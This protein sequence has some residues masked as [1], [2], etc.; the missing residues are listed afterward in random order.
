MAGELNVS[1]D[2]VS[3]DLQQYVLA[4]QQQGLQLGQ[5]GTLNTGAIDPVT[6]QVLFP[7]LPQPS[8]LPAFG[9]QAPSAAFGMNDPLALERSAASVMMG[10]TFEAEMRERQAMETRR[11]LLSAGVEAGL[12]AIPG[13]G[14][15]L[16]IGYGLLSDKLYDAIGLW[17]YD[18]DP[19]FNIEDVTKASMADQ[20]F[21][22]LYQNVSGYG[23]G[24]RGIGFDATLEAIDLAYG[25]I[26]DLGFQGI[27]LGRIAPMLAQSGFLERAVGG[28]GGLDD[29]QAL[30][31]AM[32]NAMTTIRDTMRDVSLSLLESAQ[33]MIRASSMIRSTD[34]AAMSDASRQLGTSAALL[35]QLT[36]RTIEEA[37]TGYIDPLFQAMTPYMPQGVEP[38]GALAAAAGFAEMANGMGRVGMSYGAVGGA[39]WALA[40]QAQAIQYWLTPFGSRQMARMLDMNEGGFRAGTWDSSVAGLQFG[41]DALASFDSAGDRWEAEYWARRTMA[42]TPQLQ[43]EALAAMHGPTIARID[44]ETDSYAGLIGG[45]AATYGEIAGHEVSDA[46]AIAMRSAAVSAR[47]VGS[48]VI[49]M[50]NNEGALMEQ[51]ANAIRSSTAASTAE[52]RQI[53]RWMYARGEDAW[54]DWGGVASSWRRGASATELSGMAG[55]SSVVSSLATYATDDSVDDPDKMIMTRSM[56][57]SEIYRRLQNA[58]LAEEFWREYGGPGSMEDAME[59][60][61]LS[62]EPD[63]MMGFAESIATE[64]FV[65]YNSQL[66]FQAQ[67]APDIHPDGLMADNQYKHLYYNLRNEQSW[68]I[69]EGLLSTAFLKGNQ[70]I[71][72]IFARLDSIS[73]RALGRM[74]SSDADLTL[75]GQYMT[76]LAEL[77][78]AS[79]LRNIDRTQGMQ[80]FVT[81]ATAE[82][83]AMDEATYATMSLGEMW[84]PSGPTRE[85]YEQGSPLERA[86][87]QL[88]REIGGDVSIKLYEERARFLEANAGA[89]SWQIGSHMQNYLAQEAYGMS[90]SSITDPV[91]RQAINAVIYNW[92]SDVGTRSETNIAAARSAAVEA[93]GT[94]EQALT[95][96]RR[97]SASR[98]RSIDEAYRTY[99][100]TTPEDVSNFEAYAMLRYQ[101]ETGVI[102]AEGQERLEELAAA[103]PDDALE[104]YHQIMTMAGT[105][106]LEQI[107]NISGT[108]LLRAVGQIAGRFTEDDLKGF[109]HAGL[110]GRSAVEQAL[111]DYEA[112][113]GVGSYTGS[114]EFLR[115]LSRGELTNEQL[116]E[117]FRSGM[118]AGAKPDSTGPGDKVTEFYETH[119]IGS[120][121]APVHLAQESISSLATALANVIDGNVPTT[122]PVDPGR[123]QAK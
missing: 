83:A 70:D 119:P 46:E 42:T 38:A 113:T 107:Q 105:T 85:F 29:P 91:Q 69:R 65:E 112:G 96:A 4:Q 35:S 36:G 39:D 56:L 123:R 92:D 22:T 111:L 24:H 53:G 55:A 23:R 26:R 79:A 3:A 71:S 14:I 100:L 13:A 66:H 10:Q 86:H 12:T 99:G 64:L 106:R 102:D 15:P 95:G 116:D 20:L 47:S 121:A 93:A 7:T 8:M 33:T 72:N 75:R 30:A 21:T 59:A 82:R 74:T 45:I 101:R 90:Y 84:G 27:E 9:V 16:A 52:M 78:W 25:G 2:Q 51:R 77:G 54:L 6:A 94:Y 61:R 88:V 81:G 68:R 19:I 87:A 115:A 44:K 76:G 60:A 17:K 110:S 18:N 108:A 89:E 37:Y 32:V 28:R 41:D 34:P 98:R 57:A 117:Q 31:D 11:W 122:T 62:G 114:N 5:P 43:A 109:E 97:M 104:H 118:A 1:M 73:Q 50:L 48:N 58:D 63:W 49:G 103:L 80:D 67:N 120:P 40:Q